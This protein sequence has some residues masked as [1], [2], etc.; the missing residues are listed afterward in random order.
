VRDEFRQCHARLELVHRQLVHRIMSTAGIAGNWNFDLQGVPS[1][2]QLRRQ[3]ADLPDD[4]PAPAA[5]TVTEN[6]RHDWAGSEFIA[7]TT[8]TRSVR[9]AA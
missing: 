5:E 8:L 2:E 4:L 9:G 7:N 6:V 1:W 3:I